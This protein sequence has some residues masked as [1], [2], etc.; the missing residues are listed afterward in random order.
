MKNSIYRELN[1]PESY[2]QV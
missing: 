2:E 1:Y